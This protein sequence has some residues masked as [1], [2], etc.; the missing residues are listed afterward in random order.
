MKYDVTI[1]FKDGNKETFTITTNFPDE[2]IEKTDIMAMENLGYWFSSAY[3]NC[4]EVRPHIAED[5]ER[6][7]F[8]GK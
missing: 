4:Y 5:Q 3:I 1:N 6:S 2:L 8:N 7:N